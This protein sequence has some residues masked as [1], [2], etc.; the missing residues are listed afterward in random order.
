MKRRTMWWIAGIGAISFV[1][2]GFVD[3]S[4]DDCLLSHLKSG[5]SED[6]ADAIIQAC[7][8]KYDWDPTLRDIDQLVR[9]ITNRPLPAAPLTD[10]QQAQ[11]L[12]DSRAALAKAIAAT[13]YSAPTPSATA[14][15]PPFNPA[16]SDDRGVV[17]ERPTETNAARRGREPKGETDAEVGIQPSSQRVY[18]DAE[19]G[20]PSGPNRTDH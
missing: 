13:G 7:T 1:F 20:L 18:T 14:G 19:V 15:G 4:R 8:R 2:I 11:A 5:Q 16:Q 17:A 6:A 9:K 12:A 3:K 10:D